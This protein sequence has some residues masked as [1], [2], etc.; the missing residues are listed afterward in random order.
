MR[1]RSSE[2]LWV[3]SRNLQSILLPLRV[4]CIDGVL[5][6]TV[7]RMVPAHQRLPSSVCHCLGMGRTRSKTNMLTDHLLLV[8]D[9]YDAGKLHAPW[10]RN[11]LDL[12]LHGLGDAQLKQ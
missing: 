1:H 4:K 5:Q 9:L 2:D 8:E 12:V 7:P 10:P 11:T 6:V 3:H